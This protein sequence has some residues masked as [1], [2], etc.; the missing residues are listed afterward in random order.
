[1]TIKNKLLIGFGVMVCASVNVTAEV[2]DKPPPIAREWLQ[3]P[4][5]DTFGALGL[6]YLHTM[7]SPT[8]GTLC[9]RSTLIVIGRIESIQKKESD[10]IVDLTV[11]VSE[12]LL[13]YPVSFPQKLFRTVSRWMGKTHSRQVSFSSGRTHEKSDFFPDVGTE[14]V[15]FLTDKAHSIIGPQPQNWDYD[16][17]KETGAD[18]VPLQ[19]TLEKYDAK[20][21]EKSIIILT[22]STRKEIV[23]GLKKYITLQSKKDADGYKA[24]LSQQAK[25]SV[26]RIS[27]DALWDMIFFLDSYYNKEDLLKVL[28]DPKSEFDPKVKGYFSIVF[29]MTGTIL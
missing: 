8:I 13:E 22:D 28:Q 2:A 14:A 17:K 5:G 9:R 24:F 19:L 20:T 7:A 23:T 18:S 11:R 25:S 29:R 12:T 16:R 26:Q 21:R 4:A 1:M 10:A 15:L 6:P 3:S 27:D